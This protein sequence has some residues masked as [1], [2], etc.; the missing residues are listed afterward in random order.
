MRLCAALFFLACFGFSI[1][2]DPIQFGAGEFLPYSYDDR[3]EPIARTALQNGDLVMFGSSELSAP[4]SF[5]IQK[6]LPKLC[7]KRVLT[8]G[9]AGTQSLTIL[10]K[11]AR[12]SSSLS[13]QSRI[14]IILSPGWFNSTGTPTKLFLESIQQE[15]WLDF[16]RAQDLPPLSKQAVTR[17]LRWHR[18]QMTGLSPLWLPWSLPFL[19]NFLSPLAL[20]DRP[21]A[22]G[23][24]IEP[25]PTPTA[26]V[27]QDEKRLLEQYQQQRQ[28]NPYGITDE[29]WAKIAKKNPPFDSNPLD[30]YQREEQDFLALSDFLK[31][32][33]VH[34][35]FIVQP[36]HRELYKNLEGYDQLFAKLE[37]QARADGHG[38]IDM[39]RHF[40]PAYLSD[41]AH[42]SEYGWLQVD[43]KMCAWLSSN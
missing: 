29:Y 36:V 4:E 17:Q 12:M 23:V 38:W 7:G 15:D 19:Q 40:Q 16:A 31:S 6:Y 26:D 42:F 3:F 35:Q 20:S 10:L 24:V 41:G 13:P 11:L 34:A 33:N 14:A 39:M 5:V 28:K 1:H 25:M 21:K 22:T 43:K 37:Q 32:K 27:E 2:A 8:T 18:D 9:Y 30:R